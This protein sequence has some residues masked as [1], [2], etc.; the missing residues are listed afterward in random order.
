[1][2]ALFMVAFDYHF[3]SD[4]LAG[5]LVGI[6]CTLLIARLHGSFRN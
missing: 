3:L 1:M 6:F 2:E 5:A 4:V